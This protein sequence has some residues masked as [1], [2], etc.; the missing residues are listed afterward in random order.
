MLKELLDY[1]K[2]CLPRLTS[3]RATHSTSPTRAGKR[4]RLLRTFPYFSW[5]GSIIVKYLFA[6]IGL[7]KKKPPGRDK[8]REGGD[9]KR[10]QKHSVLAGVSSALPVQTD[11]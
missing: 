5:K 11:E 8:R 1:L 6:L 3:V 10:N 7:A 9:Y 4:S 2:G